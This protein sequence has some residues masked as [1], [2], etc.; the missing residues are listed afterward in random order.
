MR[1]AG[2]LQQARQEAFALLKQDP[3]LKAPVHRTLR[4]AMLRRWEEKLELGSVS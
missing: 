3:Q 1:D 4:E 2:L